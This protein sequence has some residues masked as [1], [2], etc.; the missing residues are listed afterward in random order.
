MAKAMQGGFDLLTSH[1]CSTPLCSILCLSVSSAAGTGFESVLLTGE[2]AYHSPVLS[3]VWISPRMNCSFMF[4]YNFPSL[5]LFPLGFQELCKYPVLSNRTFWN[6][7][8]VLYLCCLSVLGLPQQN[9]KLG[10]SE[11]EFVF[12]QL[13]RL[14]TWK[15]LRVSLYYWETAIIPLTVLLLT[16]IHYNLIASAKSLFKKNIYFLLCWVFVAVC[17]L[18]LVVGSRGYSVVVHRLLIAVAS[19]V[20]GQRL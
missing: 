7:E 1:R 18:S 17:G 20:A 8:D 16:L 4:L 12:S 19:V 5:W 3:A 11:Q 13:W 15:L 10:V 6:C 14:E 2:A 9:L